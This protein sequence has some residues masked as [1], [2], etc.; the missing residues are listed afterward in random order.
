MKVP[1]NW[2]EL[3]LGQAIELLQW[4]EDES[5]NDNLIDLASILSG[6]TRSALF[7][8]KPEVIEMLVEPMLFCLKEG[9]IDSTK[10][11][12][13][14]QY[15]LNGN[16]YNSFVKCG[17]VQYGC[18]DVFERT[19]KMENKFIEKIPLLIAAF[20]YKGKFGGRELDARK[21]IEDLANNHVM[22]MKLS[23]AFAIATFFLNRYQS[24][25]IAQ[26]KRMLSTP[27][28]KVGL[29]SRIWRFLESLVRSTPSQEATLQK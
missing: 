1:S 29:A 6:I 24:F 3:S 9:D 5:R 19:L 12:S 2:S 20:S 18:M 17:E 22:K 25:L 26:E 21:D 11:K 13:P 4:S 16:V 23:E 28:P 15:V 14:A 8:Q 7:D 10:W 27:K